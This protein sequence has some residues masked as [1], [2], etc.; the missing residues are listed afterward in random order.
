MKYTVKLRRT[1]VHECEVEIDATDQRNAEDLAEIVQD[2]LEWSDLDIRKMY[3]QT[4]DNSESVAVML[5]VAAQS[6]SSSWDLESDD[7]EVL[8][9][10]EGGL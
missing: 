7:F 5:E 9:V 10:S 4:I 3:A 8:E 1:E 6:G 2:K